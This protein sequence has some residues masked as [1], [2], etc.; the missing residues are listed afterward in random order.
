MGRRT[1][2]SMARRVW[3][4]GGLGRLLVGLLAGGALWLALVP[5]HPGVARVMMERFHLRGGR[6]RWALLQTLPS[7]YNFVNVV[8]VHVPDGEPTDDTIWLN[9]YPL[10]AITYTHRR[11]LAAHPARLRV[12]TRFGS[13]RLVSTCRTTPRRGAI[14]VRCEAE[15]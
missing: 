6:M 4:R 5:L 13:A 2:L 8:Q 12:E 10:R 14:A 15:P 3:A 9:H 1:T 7:M 11:Q